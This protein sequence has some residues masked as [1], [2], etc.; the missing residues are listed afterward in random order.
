MNLTNM[1]APQLL[2]A[3]II[4]KAIEWEQTDE[5]ISSSVSYEDI[6]EVYEDAYGLGI[7]DDCDYEVRHSG[8]ETGLPCPISRHYECD[9]VAIQV[10]DRWVGFN[11]WHGGGKHSDPDS[12]EWI[13]DAYFVKATPKV[14]T[15]YDFEK[16]E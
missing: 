1:T 8:I 10:G 7:L 14:I 6:D 5:N 15:S 9:A 4:L 13:E 16:E 2:K 3:A 11:Y 12:I